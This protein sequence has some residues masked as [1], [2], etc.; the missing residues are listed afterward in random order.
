MKEVHDLVIGDSI[1]FGQVFVCPFGPKI[2][3]CE[4]AAWGIYVE[5][6]FAVISLWFL[7]S[8]VCF[9]NT[10]LFVCGV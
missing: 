10:V 6:K 4:I 5:R 7:N 3:L 8:V 2:I 1:G 9:I